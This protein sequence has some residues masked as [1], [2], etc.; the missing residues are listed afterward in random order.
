ME[1]AGAGQPKCSAHKAMQIEVQSMKT[2][3]KCN[4]L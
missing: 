4:H 1:L 3:G 2:V